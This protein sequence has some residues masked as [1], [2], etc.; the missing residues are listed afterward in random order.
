M[1]IKPAREPDLRGG[2]ERPKLSKKTRE[3]ELK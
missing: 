3:E 1:S 2:K